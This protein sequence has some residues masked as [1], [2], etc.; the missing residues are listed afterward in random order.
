MKDSNKSGK[1]IMELYKNIKKAGITPEESM[2]FLLAHMEKTK[3]AEIGMDIQS[4]DGHTFCLKISV[5]EGSI[6]DNDTPLPEKKKE[7]YETSMVS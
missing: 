7:K 6:D 1:E 4:D 2:L 3:A 5:L